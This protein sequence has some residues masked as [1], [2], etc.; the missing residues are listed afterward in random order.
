[1]AK[2]NKSENIEKIV[3]DGMDSSL[4]HKTSSFGTEG[5]DLHPCNFSSQG[6]CASSYSYEYPPES[7]PDVPESQPDVPES[8]PDV[9]ESQPNTLWDPS[10]N[11]LL[12]LEEQYNLA[13][14]QELYNLLSQERSLNEAIELKNK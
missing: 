7:Q 12:A 13:S 8:Q 5:R 2:N 10:I 9:P 1:M 14:Q 11:D 6:S 4:P 3:K